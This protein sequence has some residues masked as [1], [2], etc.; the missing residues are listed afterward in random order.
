MAAT[1]TAKTPTV[2]RTCFHVLP[3]ASEC[4]VIFV[5]ETA[6]ATART[7]IPTMAMI[8]TCAGCDA[9][10]ETTPP[11]ISN[12]RRL[13][14]P[15]YHMTVMGPC[16][17]PASSK[18][19]RMSSNV[20]PPHHHLA[21]GSVVDTEQLAQFPVL[22]LEVEDDLSRAV[23]QGTEDGRADAVVHL[24]RPPCQRFWT[25]RH[26]RSEPGDVCAV[27]TVCGRGCP[28]RNPWKD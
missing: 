26:F 11:V 16:F 1:I 22:P 14:C 23:N 9:V 24:T 17:I 10:V 6:A 20:P 4:S 15:S 2:A 25:A 13:M 28:L 7:T 3:C 19:R 27:D 12:A 8:A 5:S 21:R 18:N